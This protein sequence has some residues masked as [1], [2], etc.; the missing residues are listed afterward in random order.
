VVEDNTGNIAEIPVPIEL[1]SAT[2]EQ[3]SSLPI[4]D[5]AVPEGSVELKSTV[6]DPEGKPVPSE[7]LVK[8]GQPVVSFTPKKV[9]PYQADIF[10]GKQKIASVPVNVKAPQAQKGVLTSI[11][12]HPGSPIENVSTVV[13]DPTGQQIPS[14][15]S[16]NET[17]EPVLAFI[18]PAVGTYKAQ[19]IEKGKPVSD[20]PVEVAS[21][22]V[23]YQP[24]VV[25]LSSLPVHKHPEELKSTVVDP[26]GNPVP[27]K[28]S[29]GPLA[30]APLQI[31]FSPTQIGK[32][33]AKVYD[34][35]KVVSETPVEVL[36]PQV[37]ASKEAHIPISKTCVPGCATALVCDP[38]GNEIPAII[39]S[40]SDKPN[41]A[42]TP[43]TPGT[44]L[45]EVF[46]K[47][48]KPLAQFP[49]EVIPPQPEDLIGEP[50][51]TPEGEQT[52]YSVLAPLDVDNEKV[53]LEDLK[54]IIR[55]ED[56]VPVGMG[57]V[58]VTDDGAQ[59]E[60]SVPIP[61]YYTAEVTV[62]GKPVS[63]VP[64]VVHASPA[65]G[66]PGVTTHLPVPINSIGVESSDGLKVAVTDPFGN[67]VPATIHPHPSNPSGDPILS[68]TPEIPGT[69]TA[70]VY[71]KDGKK[72]AEIPVS[73]NSEAN[74]VGVAG[75]PTKVPLP[76]TLHPNEKLVTKVIGPSG[77]E[78]PSTI[79][80]E[81]NENQ[82]QFTPPTPGKYNAEISSGGYPLASVPVE[83]QNATPVP[84]VVG[85]K[86]SVPVPFNSQEPLQIVVKDPNGDIV[87]TTTVPDGDNSQAIFTPTI[88]GPHKVE[89]LKDGQK[90]GEI[91]VKVEVL[92][93]VAGKSAHIDLPL[94]SIADLKHP[95]QLSLV[96]KDPAGN[97]VP[98]KLVVS[99]DG[100]D[101]TVKFTPKLPGPY[102]A[103]LF[104][105]WKKIAEVPVT[106]SSPLEGINKATPN[107]PVVCHVPTE[108]L[109]AVSKSKSKPDKLKL[110]VTDPSGAEIPLK[111][112]VGPEDSKLNFVPEVGGTY[113][114]NI[115]DGDKLVASIPVEVQR[116]AE[117]AVC[118]EPANISLPKN[119][120]GPKPKPKVKVVVHNPQG[121]V[122]PSKVTVE[123]DDVKVQFVPKTPGNYKGKFLIQFY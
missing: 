1:A 43:Q 28:I 110:V 88:P 51:I 79:V 44:H 74:P 81:G 78:I 101:G 12:L 40:P 117:K 102:T 100:T 37:E 38:E 20:F 62:N 82:L 2:V 7:V 85:V 91:P 73:I 70:K 10:N 87:P 80:K 32:H 72:V 61:G 54:T 89:V 9:G 98:S 71:G 34:G 31:D 60:C 92:E 50:I 6:L 3:P 56:G 97:E 77:K 121:E 52:G 123:G 69:H 49:V 107:N 13:T 112:E 67:T 18:P 84:V 53:D 17:G 111:L 46:D 29:Q 122:V 41:L 119:I 68:F 105:G 96:V 30:G 39:K 109:E 59:L 14:T 64:L 106:A 99:P 75:L 21:P 63:S 42:F 113:L 66:G 120:L 115:Y 116:E 93:T 94:D 108:A 55:D 95:E 104:E 24:A 76:S 35:P 83:I 23:V 4:P 11:P 65:F 25:P 48:G 36:T 22:G 27:S 45:V 19:V 15:I 86:S 33:I 16:K 57:I 47:D 58:T 103:E 26:N 5:E 114:G 90:V 118:L 8:N